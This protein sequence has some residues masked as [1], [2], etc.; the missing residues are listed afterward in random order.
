MIAAAAASLLSSAVFAFAVREG[1]Y[2]APSARFEMR[3]VLLVLRD[4]GVA[5]ATA[6]YLGHMWELYAMWSTIGAFW[7]VVAV[8]NTLPASVAAGRAASPVS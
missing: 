2:D 8:R 1:P 3:A 4:R 7:T 6:G 5:L